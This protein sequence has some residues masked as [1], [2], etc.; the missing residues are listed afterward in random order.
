[1][2]LSKKVSMLLLALI[3]G[4]T[5]TLCAVFAVTNVNANTQEVAGD[6]FVMEE[7]AAIKVKVD[8]GV[9]D[10]SDSGIRFRV[11]MGKTVRDEIVN[12]ANVTLGVLVFPQDYLEGKTLTGSEDLKDDADIL[13]N[14]IDVPI[15]E[16]KIY[17]QDGGYYANAC[18]VKMKVENLARAYVAVAY[19]E[20]AGESET[21]DYADFNSQFKR[22]IYDVANTAAYESPADVTK[23]KTT[24]PDFASETNAIPLTDATDY[25]KLS[26]NVAGGT[27]YEGCNFKVMDNFTLTNGFTS[28]ANNFAGSID[29]NNKTV[30]VT[31]NGESPAFVEDMTKVTNLTYTVNAMAV[32]KIIDE[33]SS[34]RIWNNDIAN[35]YVTANELDGVLS[36]DYAGN[37]TYFD[38]AGQG[39][40]QGY[41]VKFDISKVTLPSDITHV[42]FYVASTADQTV[43][44][45]NGQING[46][47]IKLSSDVSSIGSATAGVWQ[48][49]LIPLADFTTFATGKTELPLCYAYVDNKPTTGGLYF[50][51]FTFEKIETQIVDPFIVSSNDVARNVGNAANLGDVKG[52]LVE[53]A[54][55]PDNTNYSGNAALLSKCNTV[56][57]KIAYSATELTEL[58]DLGYTH[59]K[60]N[61]L[62]VHNAS[63]T[64]KTT[65]D[66]IIHRFK[67]ANYQIPKDTWQSFEI[68][69]DL[70]IAE[71]NEC[72]VANTLLLMKYSSNAD[73][74]Y[75]GD[76]TLVQS[77]S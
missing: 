67:E 32:V 11:F 56:Y 15:D 63:A 28:I 59:F 41:V 2:K 44:F 12:N 1:M 30:D 19:K 50:S 66:G 43:S 74:N 27:T 34:D 26:Q 4:L 39:S 5:F 49:V 7:K 25:A 14:Y 17:E 69:I 52:S 64:Y 23:I 3:A 13:P 24:Y 21:R 16:E 60:F 10:Q 71:M 53:N 65:T 48:K 40:N 68:S 42:Q 9:A 22:S 73:S 72:S 58:K 55:L 57:V 70:V 77:A 54:D 51:D 18:V 37:A 38:L 35:A 8:E 62:I 61:V 47:L 36:G 75:V 20:T 46:G 31:T 45:L 76:I 29:G 33:A 6:T